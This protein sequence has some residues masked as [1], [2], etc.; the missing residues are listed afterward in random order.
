[1]ECCV[2]GNAARMASRRRWWTRSLRTLAIGAGDCHAKG[3]ANEGW[4]WCPEM[5]KQLCADFD[6]ALFFS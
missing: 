6:P 2:S 3:F 1:M 5:M 4:G